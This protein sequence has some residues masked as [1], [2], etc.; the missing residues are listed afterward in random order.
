M[1]RVTYEDLGPLVAALLVGATVA[2]PTDTVYGL[3]CAAHDRAAC[4][5]LLRS[6]GRSMTKPSAIVAGT[7]EGALTAVLPDLPA[8]AADRIRRLLPG[9]LTLVVPNSSHRY[10]WLCGEEPDRIGLRVPDL[11]P[12]LATAI[13]R[14]PALLLTSANVAGAPPAVAFADLAPVAE[15][16][17]VALDGGV[18]PGGLPSTVVDVVGDEPAI[19]REGPVS[20]AEIRARL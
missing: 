12:R 5:A 6:K 10:R 17:T 3:A 16:A 19:V 9:P 8:V 13:D 18:C 7:V 14:V 4:E 20:L 11:D 1:E 2:I 15:I